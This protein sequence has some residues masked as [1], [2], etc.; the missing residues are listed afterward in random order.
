MPSLTA[1]GDIRPGAEEVDRARILQEMAPAFTLPGYDFRSDGGGT[2]MEHANK[3]AFGNDGDVMNV[4][5]NVAAS[6]EMDETE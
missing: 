3:G 1:Q 6:M 5:E 2:V 4:E